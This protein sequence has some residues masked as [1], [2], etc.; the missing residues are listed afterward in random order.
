MRL[1]QQAKALVRVEDERGKLLT[2]PSGKVYPACSRIKVETG[3]YRA[4]IATEGY[5]TRFRGWSGLALEGTAEKPTGYTGLKRGDLAAVP[6][7][8]GE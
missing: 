3:R 5:V 7:N 6:M 8:D 4:S 2:L 1:P